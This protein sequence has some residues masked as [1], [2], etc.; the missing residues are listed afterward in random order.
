MR[1]R[2]DQV[3][4]HTYVVSRLT[5][6]LVHAEPDAPESP[7]RRTGLGS[8]AGLLI[9]TL[10]V[11]G[12]MVWGLISPGGKAVALTQGQLLIVNG[13]GA[14]D[15]YVDN[16][17]RPVLNWSSALM[18]MGG[19]PAVT[20]ISPAALN[21]IAQGQP[22]GIVGAPD[23]LPPAS[24]LNTG[25]WLACNQV[26]GG[27]PIVSLSV[28]ARTNVTAPP[29]AD[30]AIVAVGD[31]EYLLWHG[32]RLRIDAP[33]ILD[34][35]GLNRAPVIQATQVWL[36]AVPAGPDLQ[37]LSVP[38]AGHPG[39]TLA[40]LRTRIGQILQVKNVGSASE[41]YVVTASGIAPVTST[42]AAVLLTDPS[43]AA[44]YPAEAAAPIGVGPATIAGA[45]A[46]AAGLADGS[47]TPSAPPADFAPGGGTVACMD[48][49]GAGGTA[50]RLVFA[51]PPAGT[52]PALD[53]PGVTASPEVAGLISVAPGGGALVR[54]EA[55][56]G[57]GATSLFLVTD[58]GVKFPVPPANVAA[59]GYSVSQ[60]ALLPAALL[61]L[62]PD[63]P[64]LDLA[65]LRG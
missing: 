7:L 10:L 30:A 24:F 45:P 46:A 32:Q 51:T 49:A 25:S 56:P 21:G 55:A 57:V 52:P 1:S 11:A 2:R 38:G 41:L 59:L 42:Q 22:L 64:A 54:L 65:P 28:G 34:A 48:Y 13:T 53:E 14:K 20:T 16:T 33:W 4:A 61:D 36:N 17:L 27:Q 15:V 50:P 37:P 40:G 31:A 62:L 47:G 8:F 35:L 18:L 6:A 23:S 5:A 63:G 3:Q 60:A 19:N 43:S 39:P 12:F 58:A 44:A 26:S 29:A 9:G